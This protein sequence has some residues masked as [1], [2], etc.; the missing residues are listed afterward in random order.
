MAV[1]KTSFDYRVTGLTES[2]IDRVVVNLIQV[3]EPSEQPNNMYNNNLTLNLT[4]DEAKAYWP[5]Q[6]FKMSLTATAAA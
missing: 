2:G 5:G 6:V 1:A 4:S 3:I